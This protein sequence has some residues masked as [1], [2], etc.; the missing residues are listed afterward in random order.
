LVGARGLERH[1]TIGDLL[2][3]IEVIAP[4]GGLAKNR[5]LLAQL[6]RRWVA[7]FHSSPAV[8]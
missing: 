1:F 8:R 2:Y 3:V 4:T 7:T 6:S 5:D